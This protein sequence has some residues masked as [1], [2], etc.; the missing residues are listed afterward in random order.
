MKLFMV[1]LL[2]P[3]FLLFAQASHA[4]ETTNPLAAFDNGNYVPGQIIVSFNE[5][6]SKETA[7]S[8]LESHSLSIET[9]ESCVTHGSG[10]PG[11]D[12]TAQTTCEHVDSWNESLHVAV[13]SV[14]EGQEKHYA[15]VLLEEEQI[16]YVEPNY[17]VT[18][19]GDTGIPEVNDDSQPNQSGF[20]GFSPVLMAAGIILLLVLGFLAF[21][22]IKTMRT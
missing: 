22:K 5:G 20:M 14:P 9:H 6:V 16:Q 3:V 13:V 15:Q 19:S 12:T 8:I 10:G 18:I 1:V 11:E 21:T 7:Q 2:F 4:Q 17:I